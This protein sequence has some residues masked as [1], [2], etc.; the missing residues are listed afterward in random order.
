MMIKYMSV[1]IL[2]L[3][4]FIFSA[5]A[6]LQVVLPAGGD[7][8][9]ELLSPNFPQSFPDDDLVEWDVRVPPQHRATVLVVNHTQPACRKKETAVEYHS[10][11]RR[12][13]LL[14]LAD[15][16]PDRILQ[17]FTM[18]LKNCE[19]DRARGNP[20]GLSAHFRVSSA[21]TGLRGLFN[22]SA[23]HARVRRY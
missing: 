16:Q 4:L 20:R 19:M 14:G 17:N 10:S 6:K 18:T 22:C 5:L 15:P 3:D 1:S 9:V 13:L 8:P 2:T 21:R 12:T 7:S 23:L 11:R